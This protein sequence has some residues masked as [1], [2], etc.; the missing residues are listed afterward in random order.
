MAIQSIPLPE[1]SFPVFLLESGGAPEMVEVE[2]VVKID[3]RKYKVRRCRLCSKSIPDARLKAKPNATECVKCLERQGDIEIYSDIPVLPTEE[4]LST[5]GDAA[6]EEWYSDDSYNTR[7]VAAWGL[8]TAA[9]F[10]PGDFD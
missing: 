8:D 1:S 5:L 2:E 7:P 9:G 10:A 4:S 6:E 3:T